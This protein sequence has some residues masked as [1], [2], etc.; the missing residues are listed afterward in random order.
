M[1]TIAR[2]ALSAVLVAGFAA[3][4][5]AQIGRSPRPLPPVPAPL[6]TPS[7]AVAPLPP[8]PP[9]PPIVFVTP[10]GPAFIGQG[11]PPTPPVPPV[12]GVPLAPQAPPAAPAPPAP[13]S[14]PNGFKNWKFE[15]QDWTDF[16]R[17]WK[18][19]GND[20]AIDWAGPMFDAGM[21]AQ[22][23][24]SAAFNAQ[25]RGFQ[26]GG[27]SQSEAQY[28]QARMLIEQDRYDRALE[29][30]DRVI[31][32]KGSRAEAAMYWKA[33]TQAKL[34]RRDDA[35]ATLAEMQK[36]FPKGRWLKDAQALALEVRQAAGRPVSAEGQ[37]DEELKLL[38]LRSLAQSDPE[39]ALPAIEKILAGPSSVR[40][41]D[42]ALFVLSQMG[43]PRSR[44][45]VLGVAKGNSNPD[46]QLRAIRYLGMMGASDADTL[47]SLYSADA[48]LDVK[49]AVI[50][51]LAMQGNG[52]ALVTLA[53][54]EK[55]PELKTELVR[56][57]SMVKS[58]E[59]KDYLLELLK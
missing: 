9:L 47:V 32:E 58:P 13:P 37:V 17:N 43:S 49:K 14:P 5:A 23:A 38:A 29:L 22:L 51:G 48:S 12:P 40:V 39:A 25:S 2:F 4:A 16:S 36:E 57:L 56:R 41:K 34:A 3:S 20:W 21:M 1:T 44:A 19:F 55:T 50:Q 33:Y 53:R 46:L 26:A 35:L 11:A 28:D 42:R 54:M 15:Y 52:K 18:N 8:T 10:S 27:R 7:V 24:Q 6:P 45:L 30:L 31:G 59:A